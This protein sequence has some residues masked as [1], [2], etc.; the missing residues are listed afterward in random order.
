MRR[1]RKAL[2]VILTIASI[3]GLVGGAL[4]LKDAF[5]SKAFWESA[6]ADGDSIGM[7]EAGLLQLKE[8]EAAYLAGRQALVEG[9]EA[10][11]AGQE[12]L[13]LGQSQYEQ[14][15]QTLEEKQAEFDAGSEK[16]KEARGQLWIGRS[17]LS[18]NQQ[19]YDAGKARLDAAA[20]QLQQNQKVYDAGRAKLDSSAQ[21]LSEKQKEYEDGQAALA[22]LKELVG[23]IAGA[24]SQYSGWQQNYQQL[25]Q[26]QAT[27]ASQGVDLPEPDPHT[28]QAYLTAID[29]MSAQTDAVLDLCGRLDE[30]KAQKAQLEA[31]IGEAAAAGQETGELEAALKQVNDDILQTEADLN[32]QTREELQQ[33]KELL[34]Q[35][36]SV[37]EAVSAGQS[38]LAGGLEY[39]VREISGSEELSEQI[40]AAGGNVSSMLSEA[41]AM[42]QMDGARFS[43]AAARILDV[44]GKL[45][46]AL[47]SRIQDSEQALTAAQQQLDEGRAQV[48]QG[49]RD[50]A[51]AKEKLDAGYAQYEAGQERL[52]AGKQK[53]D[54]GYATFNAG[55]AEYYDGKVTLAESAI[56]LDEGREKLAE[57]EKELAEGREKLADA[58]KQLREGE[59]QLEPFEDG[60]DQVIEGLNTAL[61]TEGY[62]GVESIAQRL[63]EGF[64]F[65]KNDT[66]L[67]IEKGL[68]VVGAARGFAADTAAAVTRE[69]SGKIIGA[70]LALGGAAV[71]FVGGLMGT[72]TKKSVKCSGIVS[73][74]GALASLAGVLST[75]LAGGVFSAAAGS[76]GS[77]LVAGAGIATTLAGILQSVSSFAKEK[78]PL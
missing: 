42:T 65:M 54:E 40:A 22:K 33:R 29:Q 5:D 43:D 12:R 72:V 78:A 73:L 35:A 77:G 27:A 68:Q 64:S 11:S 71:A 16:L 32:G 20:Q 17:T 41:S 47:Q 59:A 31:E 62:P 3:F 48:E 69:V 34:S 15:L 6:S 7:L 57:A 24:Q 1:A 2:S 56:R 76:A 53:L 8:N 37:P 45:S 75:L 60:R 23:G 39:L 58:E 51:A 49:E 10:Y 14:G 38:S 4:A 50:L 67:D 70:L 55:M 9:R 13:A 74:V 25:K 63:G 30:L 46:S 19:S 26:F 44:L 21:Q 36:R 18:A 52:Q 66:D 28:A 61:A